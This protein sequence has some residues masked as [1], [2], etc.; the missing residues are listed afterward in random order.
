MES[1]SAEIFLI[2]HP[3]V[4]FFFFCSYQS[5]K[6]HV[7]TLLSTQKIFCFLLNLRFRYQKSPDSHSSCPSL[8][9]AICLAHKPWQTSS[10]CSKKLSTVVW[11]KNKNVFH[12]ERT[13][14]KYFLYALLVSYHHLYD[15][16]KLCNKNQMYNFSII[17]KL[18]KTLRLT[19]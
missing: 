15:F 2:T 19:F 12:D 4:V 16:L 5:I 18:N 11:R 3:R 9:A 6:S 17:S 7:N 8:I 14:A 1:M 10:F 13:T